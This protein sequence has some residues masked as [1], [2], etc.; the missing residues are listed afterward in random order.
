MMS[1]F[2]TKWKTVPSSEKKNLRLPQARQA[3][4]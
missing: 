4:G 2:T 1:I 3:Q